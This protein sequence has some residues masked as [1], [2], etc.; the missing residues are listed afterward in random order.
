MRGELHLD[1]AGCHLVDVDLAVGACGSQILAVGAERQR[2][3]KTVI[4]LECAKILARLG[5]PETD[6]LVGADR[7][8]GLA[9]GAE[10]DGP[11]QAFLARVVAR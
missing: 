11:D 4:A 2:A 9:I 5:L 1:G 7:G 10:H 3:D 8:N 6:A